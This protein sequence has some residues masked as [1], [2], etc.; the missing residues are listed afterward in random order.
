[1]RRLFGT[2]AVWDE[3]RLRRESRGEGSKGREQPK[4]LKVLRG[5]SKPTRGC[6]KEVSGQ[7]H[8]KKRIV[9]GEE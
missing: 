3:K 2:G 4:V 1:M 9:G 8:P 7:T 6:T 5:E